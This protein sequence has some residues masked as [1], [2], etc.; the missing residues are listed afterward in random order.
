MVQ[1]IRRLVSGVAL[2]LPCAIRCS[3]SMMSS[4]RPRSSQVPIVALPVAAK[5]PPSHAPSPQSPSKNSLL[6]HKVPRGPVSDMLTGPLGCQTS[7]YAILR[8]VPEPVSY[9]HLRAHET[10]HDLVCRLL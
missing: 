2:A 6:P 1:S 3:D 10:R 7:G 8:T 9:T 4:A 5:K